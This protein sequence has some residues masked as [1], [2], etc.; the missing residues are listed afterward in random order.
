MDFTHIE[1]VS[2]LISGICIATID[3]LNRKSYKKLDKEINLLTAILRIDV[4]NGH[5][6]N[7][8]IDNKLFLFVSLHKQSI[9]KG[10]LYIILF[11]FSLFAL[12][13]YSATLEYYFPLGVFLFFAVSHYYSSKVI[14]EMVLKFSRYRDEIYDV[15]IG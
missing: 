2:F 7:Q 5:K 6:N 3:Y 15:N 4:Y 9:F 11:L 12:V 14:K 8:L 13:L 1:I 10:N